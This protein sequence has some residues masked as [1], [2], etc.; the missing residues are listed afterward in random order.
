MPF[1]FPT[2]IVEASFSTDPAAAPSWVDIS[3]YARQFSTR[4]GRS[5]EID[6]MQTGTATVR[7]N[8]ADRRFDQSHTAGPYYPNVKPMR[9]VRI[10]ATYASVTYDVFTGYAE[11]W[12]QTW[13]LNGKMAE[14]NVPLVD[15]FAALG[16]AAL[17]NSYPA[18]L[19]GARINAVLTDINWGSGQAGILG[20]AVYGLLGSTMIIAP[21]GDRS[22]DVGVANLAAIALADTVVLE[23]L[24]AVNDSENGLFFMGKNGSV[25]FIS[26]QLSP[27]SIAA[28]FGDNGTTELPYA[29]LV[30][31]EGQIW[32]E[33]RL[34]A[35]GGVEQTASDSTSQTTYFKRSDVR[36]GYLQA[37]DAELAALASWRVSRFKDPLLRISSMQVIPGRNPALLW[38]QVLGREIGDHVLVN[39][40]PP[41]GGSV[42]SQ[43]SVIEGIEHDATA[44]TWATRFWLSPADTSIYFIIGDATAGKIGTGRLA[45]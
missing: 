27:R 4:R 36:S 14:V 40:Q 35:N 32:N 33:V 7:M 11:K 25:T 24:L 31:E 37:D 30:I 29:D 28:T 12:P 3:A 13:S 44:D 2:V 10:R 15:G 34:T 5:L 17:S 21:V 41:G 18:Q 26:R 16:Y 20:D 8:N 6:R 39:R 43:E 38:P 42:I 1:S 45:Y 22:I 19:S 9:R 23:H